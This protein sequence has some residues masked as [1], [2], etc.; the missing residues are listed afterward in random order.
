MVRIASYNCNSVRANCVNVQS[1]MEVTDIV[2]LQELMLCKSD[3][4]FLN[5]LNK[6]FDN[7][8]FVMDRES[9]GII[10][11]R[12]CRGVSIM[13]RKSLSKYVSPVIIDDSIIGII[14]TN[15]MSRILLLNVYFPCDLQTFEAIDNYRL[16]LAKVKAVI[17][18]NN[19]SDIILMG[20]F[21]ADPRKGRFWKELCVLI[22][23]FSLKVLDE[24]L[25]QD[26][27]TYLCP[28][29]N[30]TSWLDHIL[31][32]EGLTECIFDVQ[33]DYEVALY[34][35]FPIYFNLIVDF[36]SYNIKDNRPLVE[37][38][39]N[40]NAMS[41]SDKK[42]MKQEIDDMLAKLNLLNDDVFQCRVI[43]CKNRTHSKRL[44]VIF[45]LM[46]EVLLESTAN[47]K[48]NGNR[49]Y[50]IIPG[51]N[52]YVKNVHAIA[53]NHFLLWKENGKP[54]EGEYLEDMKESRAAFR[55]ALD[56]CKKNEHD[57]RKRKILES[58]KYKRYE[59]FWK[60]IN[61]IKKGN[62]IY[63]GSID[64]E[65]NPQIIA[66][67]F[68]DIYRKILDKFQR[69]SSNIEIIK[70]N[71]G[72]SQCK[73]GDGRISKSAICE[74]IK[75][76]KCSIGFDCV[77]S[78]HLKLCSDMYIESLATLFSSFILHEYSPDD[79]LRG[80]INPTVKDR[81]KS[82][83]LSTNYRPVMISSV[84]FK[85]FEYCL[86][87]KMKEF[88]ELNDR[89]HGF[90]EK[91]ST[92][93]ACFVLKETVLEYTRSNSKVYACFLDISKAFDSVDHEILIS[94]LLKLGIPCIYVNMIRYWYSN[95]YVKVRYQNRYSDEWL[96]CN[97][98][99][100][101]GVLSGFL[102]NV[103]INDLL[104][105]ISKLSIGCKLGIHSSNVI[106]YADDL[107]LLASSASSLQS[108]LNI[109]YAELSRLELR[110]N[111]SKSKV[112]IFSSN[113]QMPNVFRPIYVDTKPMQHV[114]SIKYLGYEIV[115]DLSNSKDIDSRRSRFYSEFNQVLRKFSD[116]NKNVKL[117]L[118][119]Q[120][121]LQIYGAELWFGGNACKSS[122][123]QF[124]VG[125][126]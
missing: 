74:A 24:Q 89:Q 23:Y 50:K 52:E 51:W 120:Y 27:F 112:M 98:V 37:E 103:Y 58:F 118:F 87:F 66:N 83:S 59:E 33:I 81:F 107:V 61:M 43:G 17:L 76:L 104:D 123:K 39:V 105:K 41:Q 114:M 122:L 55:S 126:H 34:D 31:Y 20:D 69:G 38:F 35:H 5:E 96:V 84:F 54:L 36:N 3:L 65:S 73:V 97:G 11:G 95:Q 19:F 47:F 42:A 21:N 121:C 26:S 60:D 117:F 71:F 124:A 108:L 18:E 29:K 85:L 2:C 90:R 92:S 111:E 72:E 8:A 1:I 56:Y 68:S 75:L 102:F 67:N 6:D 10:E 116:L 46:K 12:P 30:T 80:T 40:W 63:P 100:Q 13:W 101:G 22:N 93:T 57:I 78:N 88:V 32:S 79:L 4:Q 44:G 15:N 113:R 86:L 48:H 25:P 45:R 106:A 82:L 14:I 94:K 77:H 125:Y 16:M 99:R 62:E 9:E 53:R 49:K 109:T 28:A 119:K 110:L 7:A 115:N 91:Y 64:N 70:N